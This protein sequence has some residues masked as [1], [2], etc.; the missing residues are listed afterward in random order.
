M[1]LHRKLIVY[2]RRSTGRQALS[3]GAQREAIE[4][5]I[6]SKS[7]TVIETFVE[8][9]S[10][11][12]AQRPELAKA[13]AMAKRQRATIV[14]AKLDRLSRKASLIFN[15]KDANVSFV[16]ADCPDMNELTVGFLAVVAQWEGNRISE[17]TREGLAAARARGK[18]LGNPNGFAALSKLDFA[19]G[20]LVRK[21]KADARAEAYRAEFQKV[22]G[23]SANQA[24]A[25]LNEDGVGT[26]SGEGSW[27][28]TTVLRV[29]KRLAAV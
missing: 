24:A 14:V 15:L 22:Q 12:T 23:L 10:G 16:A 26:P 7:G 1:I 28:H 4:R 29:R 2:L 27:Q 19:K 8:T 13:I 20:R 3:L 17:R 11:K 21:H 5:F 6:A 9:E 25:K 18:K